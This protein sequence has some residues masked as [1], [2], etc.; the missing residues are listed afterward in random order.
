ME[1]EREI[2]DLGNGIRYSEIVETGKDK[3]GN[4]LF[5]GCVSDKEFTLVALPRKPNKMGR[6]SYSR[7]GYK[8]WYNNKFVYVNEYDPENPCAMAS[9]KVGFIETSYGDG[10]GGLDTSEIDL[11]EGIT[12]DM[13]YHQD[14]DQIISLCFLILVENYPDAWM[15]RK[16]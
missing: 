2:I 13:F 15:E 6:I 9:Y 5:K 14:F 1:T 12:E 11:P 4:R 3:F 8:L 10:E 16:I 7:Q